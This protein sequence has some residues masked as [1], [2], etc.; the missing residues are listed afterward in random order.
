MVLWV[1]RYFSN[2][3]QKDEENAFVDG[4]SWGDGNI[5][6]RSPEFL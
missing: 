6:G 4:G 3:T 1:H 5:K 2:L